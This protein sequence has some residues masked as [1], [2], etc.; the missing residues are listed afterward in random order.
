MSVFDL[1]LAEI[2]SGEWDE[3]PLRPEGIPSRY[4]QLLKATDDV[5]IHEEI[6]LEEQSILLLEYNK[7]PPISRKPSSR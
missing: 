5:L 7:R 4:E 3:D 1:M 6:T 2:Q